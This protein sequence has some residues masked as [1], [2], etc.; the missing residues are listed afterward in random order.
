MDLAVDSVKANLAF[1][2]AKASAIVETATLEWL[3]PIVPL[4]AN[5]VRLTK[6]CRHSSPAH[7]TRREIVLSEAGKNSAE[8]ITFS[9]A[10]GLPLILMG[11]LQGEDSLRRL[12]Q[13]LG[14]AVVSRVQNGQQVAFRITRHLSTATPGG[15][16][17][18][19]SCVG[20]PNFGDRLGFHLLHRVIPPSAVVEHV[21][22]PRLPV[23]TD[24][25]LLILCLGT[26]IFSKLLTND[27]LNAVQKFPRTI[28]I[29]GTQYRNAIDRSR[30]GALVQSLD[31]WFARYEEDAYLYGGSASCHHLGDWL[32][33]CFHL[34][35]P[36]RDE[37]LTIGADTIAQEVSLDRMI[38]RIQAHR[39]VHS[40]RLHP[41]LCAL[42]SAE[43]VS[44]NE[45]RELDGL[46]SSGKFRSLLLDVFGCEQ[47]EGKPIRVDRD[48]V[49]RYK[50][51]VHRGI[52]AI[53]QRVQYC[54]SEAAR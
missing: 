22:L 54:L 46:E 11:P 45:Q 43:E 40:A 17:L 25:D 10:H 48:A 28:G 44:Y 14:A 7:L 49:A 50:E 6:D 9:Q 41:F 13:Q 47:D 19:L 1:D 29:F 36:T 8:I 3:K 23:R 34:S 35:R 12:L 27:L 52:D 24:Y 21:Y 18:V 31:T 16:V 30:M 37:P 4:G 42:T 39:V 26:S 20:W 33:D 51:K 15:R 38:Q 2:S 5:L 53:R 32:V